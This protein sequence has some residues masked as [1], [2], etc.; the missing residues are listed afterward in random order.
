M[1]HVTET[2]KLQLCFKVIFLYRIHL[3]CFYHKDFIKIGYTII[4][5]GNF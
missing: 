4:K 5:H 1:T 2:F 3:T